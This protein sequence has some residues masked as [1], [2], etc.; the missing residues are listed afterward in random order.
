MIMS[1]FEGL[2]LTPGYGYEVD[3][4]E[5]D[6]LGAFEEEALSQEDVKEALEDEA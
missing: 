4:Q 3:P 6:E 5:A 1:N 2:P